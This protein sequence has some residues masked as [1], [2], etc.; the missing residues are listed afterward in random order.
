MHSL[1]TWNVL[2][3]N[4]SSIYILFLDLSIIHFLNY[5]RI[6]D[7]ST[8]FL[9]HD[10]FLSL[11][12]EFGSGSSFH[13]RIF[14]KLIL[15][16]YLAHFYDSSN[17][18]CILFL[19]LFFLPNFSPKIILFTQIML[20]LFHILIE[21]LYFYDSFLTSFLQI[22]PCFISIR[23]SFFMFTPSSFLLVIN[24]LDLPNL[25]IILFTYINL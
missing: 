19:L 25:F 12:P 21:F 3:P 1:T 17:Y 6:K 22:L 11:H 8:D 9:N 2:K 23:Q 13:S 5:T 7:H 14:E 10:T 20:F 4:Q 16:H 18:S 24:F 15:F